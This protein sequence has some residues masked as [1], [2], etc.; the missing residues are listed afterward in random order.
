[1]KTN[2]TRQD[3]LNAIS[4]VNEE[5][6]YEIELN[7]D[8]QSGRWFNFTL[9]SKSKIPGARVSS[10][11]RNLAKASWHAHGYIFDEIFELNPDCIIYS[12]GQ[13]ITKN[14][15]TWMDKNIGSYFCPCYF[16]ETSI[17]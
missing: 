5:Y 17:L 11:G 7:R 4:S 16:S 3:V 2:A 12:N 9:K 6:S 14:E 8:E 1:M 10:S 13:K 15:G